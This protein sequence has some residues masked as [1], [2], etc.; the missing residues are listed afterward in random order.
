MFDLSFIG[1]LVR[2]NGRRNGAPARR[3]VRSRLALE[4][5]EGRLTPANVSTSLVGGNLT[6]TDSGASNLTISQP[7]ANVIRI[8]PAAGTTINGQAIAVTVQGV[9]GN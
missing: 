8:T 9:T 7:A 5:L 6:I 1:K 4:S 2:R 3:P